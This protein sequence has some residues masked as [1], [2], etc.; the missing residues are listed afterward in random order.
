MEQN[1]HKIDTSE[2]IDIYT[3]RE[4]DW[5]NGAI[6]YQVL[7]DRFAPSVNIDAKK[8]LYA[9]PRQLRDW[10]ELPQPGTFI[11]NLKIWSQELDFWGGDIASL[12]SHLD[13]IQDLG[14]EVL[15]LNP[16]QLGFTSHK[17]DSLDFEAISPELGSR[18]DV[19]ELAN[20]LHNRNMKLVLDGVF[21]HMGR[22]ASKFQ[23]AEQNAESIWRDWFIFDTQIPGGARIWRGQFNLPELNLENSL[24]RDYL[25]RSESSIVRSYLRDGVDGWRLDTAYDLGHDFLAELTEAA[26]KENPESLIVGEIIT[27]P[28][29]WIPAMD[30]VVNYHLRSLI[31]LLVEGSLQS[32]TAASMLAHMVADIGIESLFK[33]WL[34]LDNHDLE[35]LATRIPDI[36]KRKIAQVLQFTLPG[37][38]NIY[39]GSELGMTGS[40]DPANRGPMDWSLVDQ[41]NIDLNWMTQLIALR[42]QYRALRIGDFRIATAHQLFAFERY[43]DYVAETVLVVVNPSDKSVTEHIQWRHGSVIEVSMLRDL[44]PITDEFEPLSGYAGFLT[45]HMPPNSVRV[46]VPKDID[47]HNGYSLY[48][49][50]R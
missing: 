8:S 6:V 50:I 47:N 9:S 29:G 46:L 44:L 11:D 5:R 4:E 26:H 21:N 3:K 34:L 18:E 28:A 7:V 13:Y 32:S 39:Y 15:Y 23:E 38:P 48:K 35:R 1:T 27:Y 20:T 19:K 45:I 49:R 16:I 30:G 12:I 24:V 22:N 43:T 36:S 25:W 40:W 37:S 42:K 14:I 2:F 33:S 31:I 17:Y 41:N 10:N